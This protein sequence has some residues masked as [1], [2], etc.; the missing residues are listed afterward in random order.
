M[1]KKMYVVF[2]DINGTIRAK[3]KLDTDLCYS[4]NGKHVVPLVIFEGTTIEIP[5]YDDDDSAAEGDSSGAA[6]VAEEGETTDTG[7]DTGTEGGTDGGTED[8]TEGEGGETDTEPSIPTETVQTIMYL[9]KNEATLLTAL[10]YL[11]GDK[12]YNK[13]VLS[14]S[15]IDGQFNIQ[16]GTMERPQPIDDEKLQS[17]QLIITG[18]VAKGTGVTNEDSFGNTVEFAGTEPSYDITLK[19]TTTGS[20]PKTMEAF[21]LRRISE[22]QGS[23]MEK[24]KLNCIDEENGIWTANLSFESAGTYILR[25]VEADG[26]ERPLTEMLTVSIPGFTVSNFKSDTLTNNPSTYQYLTSADMVKETFSMKMGADGKNNMPSNVRAIFSSEDGINVAV[27][28]RPSGDDELIWR[29][30]ATFST[31]GTYTMQYL[32][33]DDEFYDLQTVYTRKVSLGLKASVVLTKPDDFA[34]NE[35]FRRNDTDTGYQYIFRGTPHDF[36][37]TVRIYDNAGAEVRGL[38]GVKL[39]YTE[40]DTDLIWNPGAG[41]YGGGDL[42]IESPGVYEFRFITVTNLT[43]GREVIEVATSADSI[44]AIPSAPVSYEGLTEQIDDT[45]Y[46]VAGEE[47]EIS[48]TFR[49]AAASRVYGKFRIE[50]NSLARDGGS[51]KVLAATH[52]E[53][54]KSADGQT[55]RDTYTFDLS[56][57][58]EDGYWILEE[59]LVTNVY[60]GATGNFYGNETLTEL[61][62]EAFDEAMNADE[63]KYYEITSDQI[64]SD[65]NFSAMKIVE[66]VNFNHNV[67]TEISTVYGKHADGSLDPFM[68]AHPLGSIEATVTDFEG[69]PVENVTVTMQYT[70]AGASSKQNGGYN[71]S[72]GDLGYTVDLAVTKSADGTK[73]VSEAIT[74]NHAGKY[75]PS[76]TLKFANGEEPTY[77]M[78][79][80]NVY[81]ATPTVKISD[82]TL[83]GSGAYSVD[84]FTDKTSISDSYV[85]EGSTC[86]PS[87]KFTTNS[88]HIFA[89]NNTQYISKI[90]NNNLT[91]WLYFKCSHADIATYTDGNLPTHRP[92]TY[93]YSNGNGVPAATLTLNGMG[94]AT[95]A[96]LVFTEK[97]GGKV[98]MITQYTADS[99]GGTYWGD[100]SS[101]GTDRYEWTADGAC[102]RFIGYMDNGAGSNSSDTKVV[103][104]T[105]T[106]NELIL[107]CEGVDYTFTIPAI[108]I[109]NPY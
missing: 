64:T 108:T 7:T 28:F 39:Y 34:E 31:S 97:N 109:H 9:P 79:V 67:G 90:E 15:E 43:G 5:L 72:K 16:F 27:T 98:N 33:L 56:A 59:M 51:Y 66:T 42:P 58:A 61:T 23:R 37:A 107:T 62:V 17:E 76:V 57:E 54:I 105:I 19:L 21:F 35:E 81:S 47:G 78:P 46:T 75:T 92:H 20:Q 71:Y 106:A 2:V 32:L 45:V 100:Y 88:A 87:Y 73:F 93:S 40:E 95:S 4:Q 77:T 69:M 83:D 74:L 86:N 70:L 12:L 80:I 50:T 60:D 85:N 96:K 30:D 14:S 63:Q 99:S 89:A 101:Y 13:D 1:L 22:T 68:T 25:D 10:I 82:I 38:A 44:T 36:A 49:N 103:A 94:E 104:G 65:A 6:T 91:A 41:V 11:E 26:I 102:K 55:S 48:V 84:V 24:V 3:A 18:S 8:G 52:T 29:G 53:S